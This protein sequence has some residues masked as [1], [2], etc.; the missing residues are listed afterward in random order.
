[1][2]GVRKSKK[3]LAI[4]EDDWHYCADCQYARGGVLPKGF[5]ACTVT[6]GTC[7]RC[8]RTEM[9]LWPNNDFDWPQ[10]GRKAWFD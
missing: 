8:G 10:Q 2:K 9:T 6:T 3:K 5:I 7:S 1:M 4:K